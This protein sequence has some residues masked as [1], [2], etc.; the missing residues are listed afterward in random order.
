MTEPRLGA[1]RSLDHRGQHPLSVGKGSAGRDDGKLCSGTN[2]YR[3]RGAWQYRDHS[4]RRSDW[5]RGRRNTKGVRREELVKAIRRGEY[6]GVNDQHRLGR[7][8]RKEDGGESDRESNRAAVGGRIESHRLDTLGP[9]L[10]VDSEQQTEDLIGA[11]GGGD[12]G[13]NLHKIWFVAELAFFGSLKLFL[14][15]GSSG[16]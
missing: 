5:R 2:V 12:R 4:R 14:G 9:R 1:G 6:R 3:W 8:A 13:L 11:P 15:G 7:A 16:D 10:G